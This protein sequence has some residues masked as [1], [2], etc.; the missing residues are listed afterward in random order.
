MKKILI[1]LTMIVSAIAVNAKVGDKTPITESQ[2][3]EIKV[4][5]TTTKSGKE[6]TEYIVI[7]INKDNK[8][9]IAYMTKTDYNK[10]N[11]SKKYNLD[12]DYYILE[13]KTKNKLVV[14]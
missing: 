8:K 4:E 2:I 13:M 12:I 7:Y 1:V 6:K 10:Y 9:K 3:K 5:T 14:E 11:Q